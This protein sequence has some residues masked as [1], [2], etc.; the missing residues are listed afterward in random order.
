[1]KYF[2][3]KL[4][5]MVDL[6]DEIVDVYLQ[7][8][9]KL[10]DNPFIIATYGKFGHIPTKEEVTDEDFSNYCNEILLNEIQFD[11]ELPDVIKSFMQHKSEFEIASKKGDILE[12]DIEMSE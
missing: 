11:V 12:Y 1:M 6:N 4:N 2:I 9:S 5:R 7:M 10:R 8:E 3:E